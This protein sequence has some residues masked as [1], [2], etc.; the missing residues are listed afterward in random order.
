MDDLLHNEEILIRYIDG[1][2]SKEEQAQLEERLRTEKNLQE[3]LYHLQAAVLAVKQAGAVESVRAIHT[4][5]MQERKQQPKTKLVPFNKTIRYTL[6]VAASLLVLFIGVKLFQ[7]A[8]LT[9]AKLYNEAF[10]DFNTAVTR[11]SNNALSETEKNYRDKD[12]EAVVNASRSVNLHPKDSLLIGLSYLHINRTAEAIGFFNGLASSDNAYKQDAEF[13]LSLSYLRNR[14]Y[15]NALALI[16]KI[17]NNPA[18]LYHEQFSNDFM[19]K[20]KK[21]KNN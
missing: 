1:E 21:W 19:E 8:Q 5:M 4:E 20:L 14:Q 16:E 10:V 15:D 17:R 13:Y 11:G 3:E 9:P 12:Y 2:L 6:A 18:H 7:A